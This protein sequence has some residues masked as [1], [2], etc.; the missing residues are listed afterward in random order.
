M[1]IIFFIIF[2]IAAFTLTWT[3]TKADPEYAG[4]QSCAQCHEKQ[5]KLWMSS[6][7]DLAMQVATDETV[8]GDFNNATFT[9]FG[10]TSRFFKKDGKFYV[11]T[12]GPGG[13]LRDYEIT[14]N[15]GFY[16][17]E[18][19]LVKFPDGRYQALNICWDMKPQD[20]G[21]QRWFHLYPG[22]HIGHNDEL[23]WTKRSQ[24]WNYSCAE[25]HSTDLKKNYDL[26]TNSYDTT[27]NEINVS[28]EACHGPGSRHVR[29]AKE[30]ANGKDPGDPERKGLVFAMKE[31]ASARWVFDE[32]GTA[33]RTHPRTDFTEI[34][35]CA[36]CHSRR[37]QVHG[38]Y[39]HGR[40]LL[41]THRPQL[42]AAP[43]YYADGQIRDE[44]YVYASFL[45][46]NMYQ[47]GVTCSDC[48]DPHSART[49]APG[50]QLCHRCHLEAKYD[51]P[52][53]HFHDE[54]SSGASCVECHAFETKYMVV[55]PRR[56]H[57]FRVPR[58]GLS[59]KLGSPNACSNC[60]Q[61]QTLDWVRQAYRNWYGDDA[62]RGP[63]YGEV[64]KQAEIGA[65]GAA[66]ALAG[67][68]RDKTQPDI[69]RATAVSYLARFLEP[70]SV[71]TIM[72]AVSDSSG[73]VRFGAALALDLFP[74]AE[75]F[76][77]GRP[78]L[79]DNLRV[80]RLEAAAQ[81]AGTPR[82][83]V[84]TEDNVLLDKA[85]AEYRLSQLFNSDTGSAH[86]NLS[87]LHIFS[88]EVK[89]AEEAL[90]TG[91][92]VEPSE[93]ATYVN[94]A[95]L[96]RSLGQDKEGEEIL[97]QATK[98]GPINAE[99]YHS[100]G[101]LYVRQKQMGPALDALEKAHEL[102]PE[103]PRFGYVYA[104]AL[105]SNNDP[106]GARNVL[107]EVL[108]SHAYDQET[109]LFAATLNRDLGNR[110]AARQ[111]AQ[112]LIELAPRNPRYQQLYRALH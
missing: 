68:F 63:H 19:Y 36:R 27:W 82:D 71:E 38:D 29:W 110:N 96:Y 103:N 18:Q 98:V 78:L 99:A 83:R 94:L 13:T 57:S 90:K 58:P 92:R 102:R 11:N 75:R 64:F 8:H 35:T 112:T 88:G 45:Q 2:F 46:S 37:I 7:H 49:K 73:I 72:A 4:R 79:K 43:Y 44:V 52:K 12:D 53:H 3:E 16:P 1:K 81:L 47:S 91:I 40:P 48:H 105:H 101:L 69:V 65:P 100:L 67:L 87:R 26:K 51:S 24:N 70:V 42:L 93:Q 50:N 86:L 108:A 107:D 9:A 76:R 62:E 54:G 106:T 104:V 66:K 80:L 23:H 20:K 22:Q 6:H 28:C 21:G 60:H 97:I 10:V 5:T 55:D 85:L 61:D 111:H 32:T 84:G 109:L 89:A 39:V 17:L 77:A 95:D 25:C 41:D 74:P 30:K 33:K 56:D 34:E 15:F 59:A 14:H 31:K